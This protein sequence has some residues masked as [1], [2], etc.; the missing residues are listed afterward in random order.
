[1]GYNKNLWLW[2]IG[3]SGTM[4]TKMLEARKLAYLLY[5]GIIHTAA[6]PCD[7]LEGR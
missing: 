6:I 5:Q 4:R 7:I 3:N 1:M 2:L